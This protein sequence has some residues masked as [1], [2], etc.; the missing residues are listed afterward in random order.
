MTF[1]IY[2]AMAGLLLPSSAIVVVLAAGAVLLVLGRAK[3]WAR[4][5]VVGGMTLLVV[6][7]ILPASDV[8]VLP[9]EQRFTRPD[10]PPQATA[11]IM[12]GGFEVTSV[13][14]A[15]GHL[16]LNE[17]AERFTE[18]ALL[19]R[20]LPQ[21]RLIFAGGD[22]GWMQAD[23][24][25][26]HD[27]AANLEAFEI[28]PDRHVMEGRSRTTFENAVELRRLLKPKPDDR[29]ILVTSAYHMPRAVGVFRAQGFDVVPWPTDY[30]TAGWKHLRLKPIPAAEGLARLDMAFKEWAGLVV[31]RLLGR[32]KELWPGPGV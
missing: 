1:S 6:G 9:L 3:L 30:R 25:A 32:T 24:S 8:L 29:F 31:Y 20:K 19:A 21:A 11:I 15:R 14:R 18:A 28:V 2:K 26:A 10:S 16:Q 22:G 13:G 12:L 4:R 23:G 7:G 17:A 27:V 5:L